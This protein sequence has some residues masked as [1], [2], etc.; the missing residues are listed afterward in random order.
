MDGSATLIG[1]IGRA[2]LQG[3]IAIVAVWAVCRLFPRLPAS[4]R[5][6]LWWLACLKLV[7]GLVWTNPVPLPVLPAAE[8]P[9]V[10]LVATAPMAEAGPAAA[11]PSAPLDEAA[12]FPWTL[13]LVGLWAAGLVGHLAWTTGQ[14]RRVR[15]IV[16]EAEPVKER[17]VVDLFAGLRE[18][19]RITPRAEVLSAEVETP[20]VLGLFRPRVLLPRRTLSRLSPA[21][22]AMT[23]CHELLHVRRGDLWLGWVPALAQR[24]FFF[25]P[26][27]RLA[28][29][30]YALAR[31]AACDAEVLR[32]L[33]PAP[34]AYGRLLLRLGVAPRVPRLAAAG[35]AP[36]VETLKRRLM[37]L[38]QASDRKR[39]HPAWWGLVVLVALVGL[40]PFQ[41]VAQGPEEEVAP[42]AAV[43]PVPEIAPV[44]E[45]APV[46]VVEP[47]PEALPVPAGSSRARGPA[48]RGGR[49]RCS[50]ACAR[51][52]GHARCGERAWCAIPARPR[53]RRARR[54]SGTSCEG[55]GSAAGASA[56]ARAANST[57]SAEG[58]ARF[59]DRRRR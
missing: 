15:A 30:E 58:A 26:L 20:Q 1:L 59:V 37:M 21:E 48:G 41:M 14:L 50:S 7:L 53:R 16:R 19:F 24:L 51:C 38:Q 3:A 54:L 6:G 27:A 23:L 46:P 44:P 55:G 2:S 5:C 43:E 11:H 13:V 18:G 9:P 49:A 34:D 28:V 31:E 45:G 52:G 12:P 35:A 47:A 56:A 17:W 40:I 33:D 25:H 10:T 32:V 39:L 36:S 4:L 22:L 29:R 8:R 42:V 57:Q